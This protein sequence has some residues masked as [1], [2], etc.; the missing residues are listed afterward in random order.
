MSHDE[1]APDLSVQHDIDLNRGNADKK[2]AEINQEV[3]NKE[4]INQE[5]IQDPYSIT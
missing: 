5:V 3:T 2:T 4:V 1:V